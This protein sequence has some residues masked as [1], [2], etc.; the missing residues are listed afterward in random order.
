MKKNYL[1]STISRSTLSFA[2]LL[3]IGFLLAFTIQDE[4][5]KPDESRFTPVVMADDLDE[6]MV[7][8]VLKDGSVYIAERK[9][10]L[11]KY[12]PSSK[13]TDLIATIPVNTKYTSAEGVVREA[14]EGLMG[15]TFD[16]NFEK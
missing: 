14:E 8:E 3:F 2:P 16:P 11:K 7:F 12:N 6:P 4:P 15:L 9:G 10:A 5:Q 13:S 1:I